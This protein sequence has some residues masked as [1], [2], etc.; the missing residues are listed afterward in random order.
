MSKNDLGVKLGLKLK[1]ERKV[2]VYEE[3]PRMNLETYFIA[4]L[5]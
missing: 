3:S 2:E 1:Y 5:I 4:N